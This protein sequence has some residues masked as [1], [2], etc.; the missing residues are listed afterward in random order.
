MGII[1]ATSLSS[2]PLLSTVIGYALVAIA[3]A[4]LALL[5]IIRDEV[6][7]FVYRP[8]I[9]P[10]AAVWALFAISF[11]ANIGR[12]SVL[13]LAAFTLL[14][15]VNVL[16]L[17]AVIDRRVAYR[18]VSRS[19]AALTLVGLP[20][21][22]VGG[23]AVGPVTLEPWTGPQTFATFTYYIP[24]SVFTTPNNLAVLAVFG[25]ITA[26]TEWVHDRTPIAAGLIVINVF[27][28]LITE[29][30]SGLLVLGTA[31]GLAAAYYV[32][33]FH[34]LVVAS[35]GGLVVFIGGL[36][37]IQATPSSS[38]PTTIALNGR[39][40]IW[41]ATA[42][43]ISHRPLLGWG[44]GMDRLV[45]D[46]WFEGPSYFGEAGTHN[47]YLRVFLIG[48][49]GA[50]AAYLVVCVTALVAALRQAAGSF[51]PQNHRVID[52]CLVILVIGLLI[53]QTFSG[54]TLFGMSVISTLGAIFVG[55]A[56]P[57]TSRYSVQLSELLNKTM[58][59]IHGVL[60]S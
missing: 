35:I 5:F 60:D 7:I 56:Q 58:Q 42:E 33:D 25:A 24:R 4:L 53:I 18:A 12:S 8:I 46:R 43:A 41:S 31:A 11:I 39:G 49:V 51:P 38:L 52:V 20:V 27:G 57:L 32:F 54:A 47:S 17:P 15:A 2:S 28:V 19:G 50:G 40:A 45:I 22:L 30:R 1:F 9:Y 13:R 6:V 3:Y 23:I 10:L 14:T 55:Y 16:I 26:G 59:R 37:A 21:V 44:L 34:G 48:G 36:L 29:S